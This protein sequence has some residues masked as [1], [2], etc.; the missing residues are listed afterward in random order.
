M[1]SKG[2]SKMDTMFQCYKALYMEQFTAK[3]MKK[4]KVYDWETEKV[5][6]KDYW[7]STEKYGTPVKM[8]RDG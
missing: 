3:M 6:V 8:H 4:T 1:L 7:L 5:T 2:R